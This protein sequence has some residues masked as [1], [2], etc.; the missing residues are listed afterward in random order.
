MN[1]FRG[2][3]TVKKI[4]DRLLS[5]RVPHHIAVNRRDTRRKCFAHLLNLHRYIA[6]WAAQLIFMVE[7]AKNQGARYSE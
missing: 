6:P 5:R 1:R 4:M 7:V 2:P 3:E